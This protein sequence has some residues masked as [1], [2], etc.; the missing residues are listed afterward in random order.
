MKR[1]LRPE[2]PVTEKAEYT[3]DFTGEK[4]GQSAPAHVEIW[5]GYPSDRDGTVY[6]L[7]LSDRAVDELM[8]YLRLR[9]LPRKLRNAGSG[10]LE[11]GDPKCVREGPEDKMD[12]HQMR[13]A[14][15]LQIE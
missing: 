13:T 6:R 11:G 12:K 14:I 7:H 8:V 3:C 10:Y 4:L 2:R 9:M 5:C 1:I 15:K